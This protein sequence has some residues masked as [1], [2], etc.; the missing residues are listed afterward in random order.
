MSGLEKVI[1][2]LEFENENLVRQ[3]KDEIEAIDGIQKD[4]RTKTTDNEKLEEEIQKGSELTKSLHEQFKQNKDIAESL[5]NATTLQQRH[6]EDLKNTLKLKYD[7]TKKEREE[8]ERILEG[9]SEKWLRYEA[10]YEKHPKAKEIR[11]LKLDAANLDAQVKDIEARKKELEVALAQ[12]GHDKAIMQQ[13]KKEAIASII[14]LAELKI[15]TKTLFEKLPQLECKRQET[16]MKYGEKKKEYDEIKKKI[17]NE[18]KKHQESSK[19]ESTKQENANVEIKDIPPNPLSLSSTTK[20]PMPKFTVSKMKTS[21]HLQL[22]KMPQLPKFGNFLSR[23]TAAFKPDSK[24][25]IPKLPRI[26]VPQQPAVKTNLANIIV[27]RDGDAFTNKGT[28]EESNMEGTYT[29]PL[30]QTSKEFLN[31]ELGMEIDDNVQSRASTPASKF[32]FSPSQHAEHLK[33]LKQSPSDA[34]MR[35]G[36]PMFQ[37]DVQESVSN[38]GMEDDFAQSFSSANQFMEFPRENSGSSQTPEAHTDHDDSSIAAEQ[39]PQ[40]SQNIPFAQPS[41]VASSSMA[42]DAQYSASTNFSTNQ[43]TSANNSTKQNTPKSSFDF[44]ES[45]AT[46]QSPVEFN[47]NLSGNTDSPAGTNFNFGSSMEFADS[48]DASPF[49]FSSPSNFNAFQVPSSTE[50][51][52]QVFNF[53]TSTNNTPSPMSGFN[54][55][56]TSNAEPSK[57]DTFNFSFGNV[58]S[59][60]D[61]ATNFAFS[62]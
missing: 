28:L 29:V 30:E 47:F 15:N 16:V 13:E 50:A 57:N 32:N 18:N 37:H 36:R 31:Q 21:K 60:P 43:K 26:N 22:P 39:E 53:T 46:Q 6:L 48:T 49:N 4:I 62:F 52:N 3:I 40:S 42:T 19:Q 2:D 25:S 34:Y 56:S 58:S 12:F 20:L 55:A 27:H 41:S 5:K 59:P 8:H 54:L 14:K 38:D 35:V 24:A 45:F 23:C 44:P 51:T 10:E 17:E 1:K 33:L 11:K 9:Y 61:G 7:E